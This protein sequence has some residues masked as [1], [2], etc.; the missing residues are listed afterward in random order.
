LLSHRSHQ[1]FHAAAIALL[2]SS[3]QQAAA[4]VEID[5]TRRPSE[6]GKNTLGRKPSTQD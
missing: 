1:F 3:N 5:G 4:E 6:A 2:P